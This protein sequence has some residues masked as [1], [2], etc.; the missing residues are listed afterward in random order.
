MDTKAKVRV[1][2]FSRG[3]YDR[4]REPL[5]AL[6]HDYNPTAVLIPFGILDIANDRL[7]IYFGKSKETS[8]FIV[9][10]LY[11]WWNENSEEYREYDEIMIE[12]DGGSAT[13]SNRSQFIKRMV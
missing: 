3:G 8:D 11:M 7:W 1:G 5:N 6:D 13:R 9:D 2:E 12:L 4:T 10:C